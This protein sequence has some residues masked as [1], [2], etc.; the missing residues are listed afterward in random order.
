MPT[1]APLSDSDFWQHIDPPGSHVETPEGGHL[2]AYPATLADGRQLLLPIRERDHGR[3]AL[4]SLII[5]QASFAVVDALADEL[6]NKLREESPDVIVGLPT[7]GLTL[8]EAT[9]RRLGHARYVPLGTSRKFWYRDELSVP[10]SSITSPNSQKRLY[11]DPRMLGL[12]QDK[13]VCVIDD[14][15]S[16]GSSMVSA[17]SLLGR[18]GITPDCLGCAM[19]QS[20]L[21][22]QALATA[23]PGLENRVFSAFDTPLLKPLPS[24]GWLAE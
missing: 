20:T 1:S 3:Y 15:I 23:S 18:T 17:L 13:R 8:A 5:N 19:R 10:M 11:I 7:L 24:G 4:A 9:A 22:R 14:V 12:L 16:T 6:A 2:H 21:W